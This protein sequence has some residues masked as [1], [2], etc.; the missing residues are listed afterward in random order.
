VC[1]ADPVETDGDA[2]VGGAACVR[3]ARA[4]RVDV[5]A[6][7][8]LRPLTA[9]LAERRAEVRRTA[10]DENGAGPRD[11]ARRRAPAGAGD[12]APAGVGHRVDEPAA[13]AR[14]TA[15]RV[16]GVIAEVASGR[17]PLR[18]VAAICDDATYEGLVPALRGI[19]DRAVRLGPL[20]VCAVSD[21]AVEVAAV[22]HAPHR[23]RAVLGR[24]ERVPGEEQWRVR[25]LALL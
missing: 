15:V 17:R 3:P 21:A 4:V 12:R 11:P 16:V 1:G 22:L 8:R 19:A 23:S 25:L 18:H 13:A 24:L 5:P 9:V 10:E 20:R 6:R 2:A 14:A 7:P